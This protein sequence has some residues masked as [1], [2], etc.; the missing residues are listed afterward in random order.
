MP[1]KE[2]FIRTVCSPQGSR[3]WNYIFAVF[4]VFVLH[5]I[6]RNFFDFDFFEYSYGLASLI[7]LMLVVAFNFAWGMILDHAHS[8]YFSRDE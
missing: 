2:S 4:T 7:G 1:I 5:L 6:A 3:H 8:R